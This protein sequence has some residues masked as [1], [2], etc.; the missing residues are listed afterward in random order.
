MGIFNKIFQFNKEQMNESN[1]KRKNIRFKPSSAFPLTI[2]IQA[3]SSKFK[4]CP[5][6]DISVDGLRLK[7]PKQTSLS[8][9][10]VIQIKVL[11]ET[12]EFELEG[13]IAHTTDEDTGIE[14]NLKEFSA[15]DNYFQAISPIVIGKSL[16]QFPSDRINQN[17]PNKIK[18]I[19]FGTNQSALTIWNPI[20]KPA[21][22]EIEA[23]EFT[24][25]NISIRGEKSGKSVKYFH[26]T[27]DSDSAKKRV[28][29]QTLNESQSQDKNQ[30]T[31]KFFRWLLLNLDDDF[32]SDISNYI[33]SY[34]AQN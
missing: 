14:L 22:S 23:W 21:A 12:H 10:E 4:K 19:F 1:E 24:F 11:L 25:E 34:F 3:N 16:K 18:S 9:N 31:E 7:T 32:P 33:R 5:I 17:D 2:S 30:Q 15:L 29:S 8:Q 13:R 28:R 6:V 27:D 26:G 20:D